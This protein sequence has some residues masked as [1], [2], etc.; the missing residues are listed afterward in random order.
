[1]HDYSRLLGDAVKR[2]R[3]RLDLTQN[4]VA[5]MARESPALRQ[6]RVMIE[7]CGE[8]EAAVII[9]VFQSVLTALRDKKALPIE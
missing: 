6:L 9:P 8:E 3:G 5:D 4:E 1:M 2:A 7:E